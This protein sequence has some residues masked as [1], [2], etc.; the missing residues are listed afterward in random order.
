MNKPRVALAMCLLVLGGCTSAV[1]Y[2]AYPQRY[3]LGVVTTQTALP[4]ATPVHAATLQIARV[5]VPAWLQGDGM[6]YRLAYGNRQRV[7]AYADSTWAAPPADLLEPLIRNA[8][9]ASGNWRAV[10]GPGSGAQAQFTLRVDLA[11]FSQV[12]T[13]PQT[14]FGVLDATATLMDAH[15]AR[16]IAQREF[17]FKVAAASVDAAGGAAALDAA[18]RSFVR[19]LQTWL[20]ALPAAQR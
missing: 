18:S 3:A 2:N 19:Q 10:L 13:A 7:A 20:R 14:S 1:R 17:H 12:F 5:G 8:L 16:V 15:S 9:A 11:D 4:P 6:V